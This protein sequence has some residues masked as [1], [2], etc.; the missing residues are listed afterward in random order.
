MISL[1][2]DEEVVKGKSMQRSRAAKRESKS[3]QAAETVEKT[4]T[5]SRGCR[6]ERKSM[7]A[8]GMQ[9]SKRERAAGGGAANSERV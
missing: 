1:W 8:A 2:E 6:E 9:E 5:S 3:M 7:Q 4:Q